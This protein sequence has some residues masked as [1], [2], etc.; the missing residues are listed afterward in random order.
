MLVVQVW[1]RLE[2]LRAK[3]YS[4]LIGVNAVGIMRVDACGAQNQLCNSVCNLGSVSIFLKRTMISIYR[5]YSSSL[6]KQIAP[7]LDPAE[8]SDILLRDDVLGHKVH[9][10]SSRIRG[11]KLRD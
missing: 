7:P 4:R 9:A 5:R 11:H 3:C 8:D 10:T 2:K 1:I 6:T